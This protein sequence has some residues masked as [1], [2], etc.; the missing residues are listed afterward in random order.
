MKK[1]WQVTA[2]T[3]GLT[4]AFATASFAAQAL[5]DD[6]MDKATAKGQSAVLKNSSTF[7]GE[8]V[9]GAD[10]TVLDLSVAT[11]TLHEN[12]QSELTAGTAANVAGANNIATAVNAAKMVTGNVDQNNDITQ[13]KAAT[14]IQDNTQFNVTDTTSDQFHTDSQDSSLHG[15]RTSASEESHQSHEAGSRHSEGQSNSETTIVVNISASRSLHYSEAFPANVSVALTG[16]IGS[17]AAATA[18]GTTTA[19]STA[20]TQATTATQTTQ[21]ASKTSETASLA[22]NAANA[23]A[24]SGLDGHD[25]Q[26]NEHQISANIVKNHDEAQ[27]E[28]QTYQTVA[29]G[30]AAIAK[31]V[32]QSHQQDYAVAASKSETVVD[33]RLPVARSFSA[34]S[35]F[36]VTDSSL[37]RTTSSS[38]SSDEARER[39]SASTAAAN[40]REE[41]DATSTSSSETTVS[42][43]SHTDA[44]LVNTEN[45]VADHVVIGSGNQTITDITTYT[46]LLDGN[47]Q[48][49]AVALNIFNAA[50]RNNI[51]AAW[52]FATSDTDLINVGGNLTQ[53]NTIKQTN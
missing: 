52:N 44:T 15:L 31:S 32:A 33:I 27:A 3:L 12:A 16:T 41:I 8:T 43:T 10:Q 46:V 13:D 17:T 14:V 40:S 2:I 29:T 48:Q 18:T 21:T 7:D 42:T 47:A 39:N 11:V 51:A 22:D 49:D 30:E 5:S 37:T 24:F 20:T 9:V 53:L 38:F 34:E 45:I 23:H 1:S 19:N 28:A 25:G 26:V 35:S 4:V 6:E 50:G 36:G